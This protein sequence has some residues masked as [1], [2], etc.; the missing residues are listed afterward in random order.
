MDRALQVFESA[1]FQSDFAGVASDETVHELLELIGSRDLD[2]SDTA[3]NGTT[4][5]HPLISQPSIYGVHRHPSMRGLLDFELRRA[6]R[7]SPSCSSPSACEPTLPLSRLE[8]MDDAAIKN[9]VEV[10]GQGWGWGDDDEGGEDADDAG[11]RR[12]GLASPRLMNHCSRVTFPK[13]IPR[14]EAAPPDALWSD[15]IQQAR[16]RTWTIDPATRRLVG[17]MVRVIP[18]KKAEGHRPVRA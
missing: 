14:P 12:G 6:G 5:A 9:L 10:Q 7:M 15:P 4:L 1:C 16:E 18:T 3:N 8:A 2:R 13:R 17:G 11:C